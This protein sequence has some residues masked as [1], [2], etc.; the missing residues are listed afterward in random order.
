MDVDSERGQ[1]RTARKH[2][3][4][5]HEVNACPCLFLQTC[6]HVPGLF[7]LSS[8]L[9]V[10]VLGRLMPICLVRQVLT[11]GRAYVGLPDGENVK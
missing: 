8:L 11:I 6:K 1:E 2:P 10:L 9:Q 5:C 4:S 7:R 3:E